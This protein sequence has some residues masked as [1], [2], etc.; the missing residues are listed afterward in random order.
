MELCYSKRY[1]VSRQIGYSDG[2]RTQEEPELQPA[3]LDMLCR[4][5]SYEGGSIGVC[6]K[7]RS[8][9]HRP[10]KTKIAGKFAENSDDNYCIDCNGV[11]KLRHDDNYHYVKKLRLQ[12]QEERKQEGL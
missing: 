7:C 10:R 6:R 4:V 3:L 8:Y 2:S 11:S 9:F 1:G 5:V 12:K